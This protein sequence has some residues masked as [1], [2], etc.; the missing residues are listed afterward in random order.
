[1]PI[2]S[3]IVPVFNTEKYIEKCLNSIINQTKK[4]EIE[5]IIINDGSTDNSDSVIKRY[6][7][8]HKNNEKIKFSYFSKT[9]TGIARTRNYGIEKA[10]GKY[11]L[12]VDS[13]DYI[14]KQLIENLEQYIKQDI[15]LIKFKLKR[16]NKL[17]KTIEK[18]NGPVFEKINGQEAF[19]KMYSE[20][21]LLDSPCI[22]LIKTEILKK[23]EFKRTYHE[24]FGLIPLLIIS[25]KTVVST[26]FYLYLYVQVQNSVTRNDDYK[27]TLVKMS[28][29]L[30]HYDNML[31]EI[32]KMNLQKTTCENIKIYY[33]NAI[34]LKLKELKKEDRKQYIKEIRK[35]KMYNN[36]K[37]RNLKQLIK[38]MLLKVNIGLYVQIQGKKKEG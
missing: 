2:I 4:E 1:M 30:A 38:R 17:G 29:C 14:D 27:K 5:I 35:R 26:P 15:D 31:K 18:V 12:F 32:S 25:A 24:D 36:I 33:T 6:I 34:I 21:V 7:E 23:H 19:N 13:D 10:K 28:D 8:K 37:V 20:D 16:I 11:I 3:F 9:N 22:Y